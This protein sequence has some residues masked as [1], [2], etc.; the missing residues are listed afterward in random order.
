M[1]VVDENV[2]DSQRVLLRSWRIRVR[3]MGHEV[4]RQGMKDDEII[5]LLHTLRPVV[6][7]TARD[8]HLKEL[9]DSR[10]PNGR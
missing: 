2:I 4:G 5:P 3:Q 6:F 9:N 10:R 1:I 7:F 8:P